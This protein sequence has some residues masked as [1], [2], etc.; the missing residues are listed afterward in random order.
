MKRLVLFAAILSLLFGV[1][2]QH[3]CG[4][5]CQNKGN[6][7]CCN[8]AK[9]ETIETL[10]VEEFSRRMMSK[11]VVLV[12]V[13]TPKEFAEGHLK[14]ATN[15]TWGNDFESL[16]KAAGIKKQFT[17]AVYCRGGR[18]SKAAAKEL[19]KKGYKVIELEGGITAWQKAGKPVE[20]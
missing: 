1:Q 17:V 8:Q 15:V 7:Q 20:K 10:S 19:V 2:A 14:G 5:N 11:N 13:R 18:R 6:G 9:T 16:W 3:S 12:D 4:K